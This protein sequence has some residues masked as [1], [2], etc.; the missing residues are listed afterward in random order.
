MNDLIVKRIKDARIERG[1]TQKDLADY[2]E[3]TSAAISDLERGKVQVSA[4]DLYKIAQLLNKPIEYFY[5]EDFGNKETQ[6]ML[7]VMRKQPKDIRSEAIEVTNL[8]LQMQS[9]EDELRNYPPDK[10]FPVEKAL[11][12]YN[13]MVP[14]VAAINEMARRTNALKEDFDKEFKA[15]GIDISKSKEDIVG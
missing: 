13:F 5:G 6:D 4:S 7:A 12:F 8:L 2:L 9:F 11:E 15:R 3:K 10:E 1:K 14:F